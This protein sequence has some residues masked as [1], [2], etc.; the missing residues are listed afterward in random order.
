LVASCPSLTEPA[1]V[2]DVQWL[3]TYVFV[4]NYESLDERSAPNVYTVHLAEKGQTR[5]PIWR[6]FEDPTYAGDIIRKGQ[7][8]F[9]YI[10]QW[11]TFA[12]LSSN[13]GDG[14][15]LGKIGSDE[16]RQWNMA[17]HLRFELPLDDAGADQNPCVIGASWNFN[18]KR[19][20]K[21]GEVVVSSG[22]PTLFVLSSLGDLVKFELF[23][24]MDGFPDLR[25][26]VDRI[27]TEGIRPSLP[28]PAD[29][30]KPKPRISLTKTTSL[31]PTSSKTNVS[32][33][34]SSFFSTPAPKAPIAQSTPAP[35]AP[36]SVST[37]IDQSTDSIIFPD[38]NQTV[39]SHTRQVSHEILE[40]TTRLD[41]TVVK[42]TNQP[43]PMLKKV[44]T[45][46]PMSKM[47]MTGLTKQDL[48]DLVAD[49]E[50]DFEDY[51]LQNSKISLVNLDNENK[52][53]QKKSLTGL[54]DFEEQARQVLA[55]G[56]SLYN[57]ILHNR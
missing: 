16:H 3:S 51:K 35:Q 14:A 47:P 34:A 17:D 24:R 27:P 56:D 9:P 12:V 49:F 44:A 28:P 13:S 22:S 8:Y 37:S 53:K 45:K 10:V 21:A 38:R 41:Q 54:I 19:V 2:V 55:N 40:K 30:D 39:I 48:A 32:S 26:T 7:M 31:F 33:A 29:D 43:P 11:N 50:K 36:P 42:Q 15:V 4:V 46:P 6:S 18:L 25:Q 57:V 1:K 23:N 20:I 5:D 52:Q